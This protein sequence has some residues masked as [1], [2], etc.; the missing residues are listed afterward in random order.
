M[1]EEEVILKVSE[2]DSIRFNVT[3]G[4]ED[5]KDNKIGDFL[6]VFPT[7]NNSKTSA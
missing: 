3:L 2:A 4:K 1:D 7:K 5:V 6:Q